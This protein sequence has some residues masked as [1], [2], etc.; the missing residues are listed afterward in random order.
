MLVLFIKMKKNFST[1]SIN[2]VS[3]MYTSVRNFQQVP[4]N[5][6][7]PLGSQVGINVIAGAMH[8]RRWS[9]LTP[10]TGINPPFT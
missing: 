7:K 3:P 10:V 4:D 5:G 9:I 6:L 1:R 2:V 8:G